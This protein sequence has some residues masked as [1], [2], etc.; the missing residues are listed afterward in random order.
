MPDENGICRCGG[1]GW[2]G[3][4]PA[5]EAPPSSE[6]QLAARLDAATQSLPPPIFQ[7]A[8]QAAISAPRRRFVL[9][10]PTR[11]AELAKPTLADAV[12]NLTPVERDALPSRRG[13]RDE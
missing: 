9:S 12:L 7:Q 3:C 4:K 5:K 1:T 10:T 11:R 13:R 2:D 8:V 6:A